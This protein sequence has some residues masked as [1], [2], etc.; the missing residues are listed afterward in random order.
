MGIHQDD[1]T[2]IGIQCT[3]EE[4]MRWEGAASLIRPTTSLSGFIRWA[5]DKAA[6]ELLD[7]PMPPAKKVAKKKMA[8]KE[9]S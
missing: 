7:K 8:K 1:K 3:V 6:E 5:L 2:R 9:V 4:K